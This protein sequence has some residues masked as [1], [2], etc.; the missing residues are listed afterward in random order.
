MFVSSSVSH[1]VTFHAFRPAA[2]HNSKLW[3]N[4]NSQTNIKHKHVCLQKKKRNFYR[5][6][7]ET[8][9]ETNKKIKRNETKRNRPN[10]FSFFVFVFF[11]LKVIY[12][13]NAWMFDEIDINRRR[14]LFLFCWMFFSVV[15]FCSIIFS[16][17]NGE[18]MV[19]VRTQRERDRENKKMMRQTT[20]TEWK[21]FFFGNEKQNSNLTWNWV[22]EG[23]CVLY[24]ALSMTA[25][26]VSDRQ[27]KPD[28]LLFGI[29][30]KLDKR[31]TDSLR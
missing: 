5:N 2:A 26:P 20:E 1:F 9:R 18:E 22:R 4:S 6:E 3:A 23:N 11:S 19:R 25:R 12:V 14:T 7:I 13:L 28:I 15:V 10:F 17:N 21:A 24:C 8:K 29:E 31:R 30:R 16:A 27:L